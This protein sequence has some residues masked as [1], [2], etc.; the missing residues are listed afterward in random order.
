MHE[1]K[2]REL[3]HPMNDYRIRSQR[4]LDAWKRGIALIGPRFFE[5]KSTSFESATDKN[6]LRPDWNVI[7]ESLG[8]LSRGEAAFLA[9]M[10]SFYNA[11]CGQKLLTEAGFP[12][13]CDIASRLDREQSEVIAE[14]FLTY[15]GW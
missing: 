8:V 9:A 6:E 1:A 15:G 10:Y 4:F 11:E 12:N 13:I 3:S 2:L 14:L 7:E 5:V